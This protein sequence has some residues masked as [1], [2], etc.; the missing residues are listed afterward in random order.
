MMDAKDIAQ[1]VEGVQELLTL[2]FGIKRQPLD[3]MLKRAGRRVP[4]RMQA[5]A[6]VLIDAEH[7]AGHPKLARQMDAAAVGRAFEDLNTHLKS[8]D[9]SERRKGRV[10][11]LAGILVFNLLFVIT[12]FILWMWWRGY[13]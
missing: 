4:K 6:Q 2:K 13:L 5:K 12:A 7:L 11:G 3:K 1:K 9:V 10:L 8:I